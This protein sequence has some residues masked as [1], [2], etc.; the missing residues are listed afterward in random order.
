MLAL[1]IRQRQRNVNRNSYVTVLA[2]YAGMGLERAALCPVFLVGLI[3]NVNGS[4]SFI[5]EVFH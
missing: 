4:E 3:T 5:A 2:L 1:E